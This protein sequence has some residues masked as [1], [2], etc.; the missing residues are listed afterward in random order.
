MEKKSNTLDHCLGFFYILNES[1]LTQTRYQE[2]F[3]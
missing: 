2:D 1:N 3:V